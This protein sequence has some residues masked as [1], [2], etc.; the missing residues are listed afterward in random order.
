MLIVIAGALAGTT[1]AG[2]LR[3]DCLSRFLFYCLA[4]AAIIL[5]AQG[6]EIRQTAITG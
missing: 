6:C 1:L 4:M 5:S 2:L 3:E